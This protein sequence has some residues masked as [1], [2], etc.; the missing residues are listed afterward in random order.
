MAYNHSLL[1]SPYFAAPNCVAAHT[2]PHDTT[3][4]RPEKGEYP[5]QDHGEE[6]VECVTTEADSGGKDTQERD[7]SLIVQKAG[8]ESCVQMLGGKQLTKAPTVRN[9]HGIGTDSFF[10]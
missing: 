3:P 5:L 1:R 7:R 9:C 2:L 8:L 4:E 10:R 6:W